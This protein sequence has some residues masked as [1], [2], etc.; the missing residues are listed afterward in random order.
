MIYIQSLLYGFRLIIVTKNQF[1]TAYFTAFTLLGRIVYDVVGRTTSGAGSSA[2]HTGYDI[3][4]RYIYI[5]CIVHL[6]AKLRKCCIKSLCL[7]DGTRKSIENIAVLAVILCKAVNN[8][9]YGQLIRN[10]RMS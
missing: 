1:L 2:R 6:F 7:R 10:K 3:L 9:I 5:N 4:I 8:Q